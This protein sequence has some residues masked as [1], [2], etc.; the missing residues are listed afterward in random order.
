MS[1]EDL[2]VSGAKFVRRLVMWV[3]FPDSL[4]T[5]GIAG[6]EVE[7]FWGVDKNARC[8]LYVGDELSLQWNEAGEL[9]RLYWL[10][11]NL[12]ATAGRLEEVKRGVP[13]PGDRRL[14]LRREPLAPARAA[15]LERE[16]Q[17]L[18][19][20]LLELLKQRN[21][22]VR[23]TVPNGEPLVDELAH[24]LREQLGSWPPAIARSPN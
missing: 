5:L 18:M 16:C 9:R 2:L 12:A 24:H 7:V 11:A 17:K 19:S 10:G 21:F 1:H 15:V 13:E 4:A 8:S 23:G 14:Q 22:R 3:T 20:S 6:S